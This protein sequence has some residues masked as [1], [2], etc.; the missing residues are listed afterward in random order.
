[1]TPEHVVA[2]WSKIV[3]FDNGEAT[4][5]ESA[6]E[7]MM[8]FLSNAD[9][10]A[11]NAA[12]EED[13]S[14]L[15][16]VKKALSTPIEPTSFTYTER[17][18]M[19]YNLGVGA[20]STQM[21]Y[22]YENA[23][24]FQALPTFGVIPQFDAQMGV[25]WDEFLPNF[26]PMLLL[27]GEQFLEIKRYPIPTAGTLKVEA[28]VAEVLDKGKAA[29]VVVRTVTKDE[30]GDV[31][32]NNESTIFIRGSGGF[33]GTSQGADRGAATAA[34]KV[35]GRKPDAVVEE[36]TTENQAVLYR[37]SGDYNPLHVDAAFA[38]VG[39]F[40]KPILH[41][42]CFFG[43]AGKHILE[44]YGAFKNIKVRFVGSVFPGETLRT[45]MWKEGG[46]VIFQTWV[47]ERKQL[48]ISA[49]AAELEDG[50][51]PKL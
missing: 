41:G 13:D 24:D 15:G 26:S 34:N 47:V 29:S 44:T 37:L 17:D 4:N 20:Q 38:A 46:K 40:P 12:E 35:P 18:V 49:A 19:L 27:H 10:R 45:E 22:V 43:F 11:G 30:Q 48:C 6:L 42:L 36:K 31:L 50:S 3:D 28:Q 21:K 25:P 1:M 2:N 39:K 14:P 51:K 7:T 8:A 32:F 23:E 16:K 33:G 5:P 9:N